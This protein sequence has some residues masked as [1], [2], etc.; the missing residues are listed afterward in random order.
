MQSKQLEL[1]ELDKAPGSYEQI[2]NRHNL[3]AAYRQVKKNKGASGI[4]GVSLAD[5]GSNLEAELSQLEQQLQNWTHIVEL[6]SNATY[7]VR[8]YS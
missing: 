3:R 6:P 8:T 1:F 4:D 2:C 5:F 7:T